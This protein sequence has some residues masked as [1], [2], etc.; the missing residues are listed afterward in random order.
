MILDNAEDL[1][2]YQFSDL[3]R[4][5]GVETLLFFLSLTKQQLGHFCAAYPFPN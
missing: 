4:K 3:F 5:G 1:Y 2:Q